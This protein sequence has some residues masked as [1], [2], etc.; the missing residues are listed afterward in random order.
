MPRRHASMTIS[1]QHS[2]QRE[3]EEDLGLAEDDVDVGVSGEHALAAVR[4]RA[5]V[6][7]P[8]HCVVTAANSTDGSGA[9]R[10]QHQPLLGRRADHGDNR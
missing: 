7:D 5:N 3:G 10:H 4:S 2:C 1:G 9:Q 8:V 6:A